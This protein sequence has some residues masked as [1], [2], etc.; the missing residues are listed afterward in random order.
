M[1]SIFVGVDVSKCTL[2][3]CVMEPEKTSYHKIKNKEEV[4]GKLFKSIGKS[5]LEVLSVWRIQVIIILIFMR[6]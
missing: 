2:D 3:F 4:I 5:G 6:F 1:K